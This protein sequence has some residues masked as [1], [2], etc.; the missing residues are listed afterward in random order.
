MVSR[1]RV[2]KMGIRAHRTYSRVIKMIGNKIC[3]TPSKYCIMLL[4]KWESGSRKQSWMAQGPYLD[5]LA[6]L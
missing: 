2:G 1:G 6:A 5:V 4:W 3:E